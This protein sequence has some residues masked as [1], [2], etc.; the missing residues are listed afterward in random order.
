MGCARSV[1]ARTD[2]RFF[3]DLKWI[4]MRPFRPRTI[5]SS[6]IWTKSEGRG[7]CQ[8]CSATST[9][10]SAPTVAGIWD[11]EAGVGDD[12]FMPIHHS[13]G[14][15]N[16]PTGYIFAKSGYWG[17]SPGRRRRDLHFVRYGAN[18]YC[19]TV[20]TIMNKRIIE[21]ADFAIWD[22][23][24]RPFKDLLSGRADLRLGRGGAGPVADKFSQRPAAVLRM[25]AA[26]NYSR[27]HMNAFTCSCLMTCPMPNGCCPASWRW[28]NRWG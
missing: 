2:F 20:R 3:L 13:A 24:E 16:F 21:Y 14:S 11:N 6:R 12:D 10:R 22:A 17:S 19:V 15:R 9:K 18:N 28:R 23:N 1:L 4:M 8:G 25:M 7:G 27:R 26:L 5:S